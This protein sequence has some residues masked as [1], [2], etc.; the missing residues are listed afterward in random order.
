MMEEEERRSS[1]RSLWWRSGREDGGGRDRVTVGSPR[2]GRL[3]WQW[4][5]HGD[6]R[7]IRR[8][9]NE[10]MGVD[11]GERKQGERMKGGGVVDRRSRVKDP[12]MA[13]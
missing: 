3:R 7:S 6:D 9:W 2:W 12:R 1:H 11:G 10:S 8:Q 4:I 5:E 13:S